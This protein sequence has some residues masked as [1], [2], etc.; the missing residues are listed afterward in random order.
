MNATLN[1]YR[2]DCKRL[3]MASVVVKYIALRAKSVP[4]QGVQKKKTINSASQQM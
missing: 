4:V 3:A 1:H 2:L